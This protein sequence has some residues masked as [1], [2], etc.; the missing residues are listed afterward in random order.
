MWRNV[1][2]HAIYQM[3]VLCLVIFLGQGLL[4][5]KYDVKCFERDGEGNCA[6]GTLNP[7]YASTPYFEL[8]TINYWTREDKKALDEAG[9]DSDALKRFNCYQL[10][11]EFTEK[12][13]EAGG[14]TNE[15]YQSLLDETKAQAA[16][17]RRDEKGNY[18]PSLQKEGAYTQ[19][20]IHMTFVF[21]SFVFMQ[22]FNQINARKLT[23]EFNIFGGIARNWLF[24]GVSAVT[25]LVQ[26]AMVDLGGRITKTYPLRLD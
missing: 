20:L 12:V 4:V 7:F 23:E 22:I 19:K 6:T 11:E 25:V 9:F 3:L 16:K 17:G 5:D 1:Y 24:L 13:A 10:E 26:M 21:Q 14:C 15:N 2:G 8:T 18:M